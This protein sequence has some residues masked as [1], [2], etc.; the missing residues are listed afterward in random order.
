MNFKGFLQQ[1]D[2]NMIFRLND[3][4]S[5]KDVKLLHLEWAVITQLDGEKSVGDIADSLALNSQET[6]EI[7]QKL[8]KA[9][10]LEYSSSHNKNLY[11]SEGLIN[12][13]EFELTVL[14]GPI[15]HILVDDTFKILKRKKRNLEKQN[16]PI[17]IDLLTNQISESDKKLIFQNNLLSKISSYLFS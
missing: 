2:E 3:Q 4:R 12:D 7:F 15:S 10:L 17:F 11:V 13:L 6:K 8:W 9:G 1:I 16:L 14:L 5:P